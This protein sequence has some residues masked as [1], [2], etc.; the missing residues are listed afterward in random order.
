MAYLAEYSIQSVL[1]EKVYRSKVADVNK[2]KPRLINEWAQFD[3]LIVDAAIRQYSHHLSAFVRV[4][5]VGG[6]HF[7]HKFRQF[8][9]QLLFKKTYIFC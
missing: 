3:Q 5:G 1:R 9:I 7:E 8:W 6:T 4:Q 2:L